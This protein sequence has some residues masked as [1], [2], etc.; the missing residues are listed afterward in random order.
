MSPALKGPLKSWPEVEAQIEAHNKFL[1]GL[2]TPA[3]VFDIRKLLHAV[4]FP[5]YFLR[6]ETL[7]FLLWGLNVKSH[8]QQ[9]DEVS[10]VFVYPEHSRPTQVVMITNVGRTLYP[11]QGFDQISFLDT[12]TILM[13]GFLPTQYASAFLR[14]DHEYRAREVKRLWQ[15]QWAD[16]LANGSIN[17]TAPQ[18][19]AAYWDQPVPFSLAYTD[20][21]EIRLVI[22]GLGISQSEFLPILTSLAPLSA[23]D[24]YILKLEAERAIALEALKLKR[25]LWVI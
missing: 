19:K 15:E 6:N 13:V 12:I 22:G 17:E 23:E 2:K 3:S 5:V 9:I 16:D 18:F 7:G 25:D 14:R 8:D 10:S 4:S 20:L 21:E 24:D 1:Q 11:E